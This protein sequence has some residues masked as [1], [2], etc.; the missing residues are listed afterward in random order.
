V[1]DSAGE[2]RFRGIMPGEHVFR[3]EG[4]PES[5]SLAAVFLG[6]R[7]ITDSPVFLESDQQLRNLRV[8]ATDV[9]TLVTGR[10]IEVDRD[11]AASDAAVVVFAADPG[12]WQWYSRRVRLVRPD[13]EGAY[14]ASGLPPG[15][16]LA[17]ATRDVDDGD[18]L[19][20]DLLARLAGQAR[21]L[22]LQAAGHI[23]L[24]LRVTAAD[25]GRDV[26]GG[27]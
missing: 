7:E 4:L 9:S 25:P 14:R 15:D 19:D 5:W 10:V 8:V 17:I 3:P 13:L 1:P 12:L 26:D 22:T 23:A 21:R 18:P 16:Y 27:R 20:H 6:G 24:D 2:F 11:D